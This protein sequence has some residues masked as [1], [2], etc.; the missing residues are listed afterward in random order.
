MG[1]LSDLELVVVARTA[2][3]PSVVRVVLR[4]P[5]GGVLP[6]YEPGAHL[7]LSTPGGHRRSY[8]LVEP[9]GAAPR[10]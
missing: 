2:L 1:W 3:T 9:G 7:T 6:G 4:D 8:S 5:Q 10:E